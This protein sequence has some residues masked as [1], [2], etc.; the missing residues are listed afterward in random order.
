MTEIDYTKTISY[1]LMTEKV[2]QIRYWWTRENLKHCG[3]CCPLYFYRDTLFM[4]SLI[5]I[6]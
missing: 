6:N 3:G 5:R 2:K 1:I 4:D